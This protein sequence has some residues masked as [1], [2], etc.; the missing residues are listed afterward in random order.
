MIIHSIR[1][2]NVLKYTELTI[3]NLPLKGLIAITGPNE[4]GKSTIGETLCFALFGRT[5]SLDYED[6]KKVILWGKTHCSVEVE[7][8]TGDDQQFRLERFLDDSGNHSAH[9]SRVG[10][11]ED[12]E[13]LARGIEK[14]ADKL[15]E[16]IG[17][18]YDEFIESFY[19][20]QREITTPHPHSYA[21]KTM[22][23][24]TTL[25]YCQE[26]FKE[27]AQAAEQDKE[28]AQA[29]LESLNEQV[30]EVKLDAG[31]LAEL[32]KEQAKFNAQKEE[33]SSSISALDEA[34]IEYQEA[35]PK[36]SQA[37][38]SQGLAG[39]LRFV[40]LILALISGGS[41]ALLT[42]M[43]DHD[44]SLQIQQQ[45]Q[46]IPN[47]QDGMV[48]WL[49]YGAGAFAL[50][51]IAYWLRKSSLKRKH[52]QLGE[53]GQNLSSELDRLGSIEPVEEP[54]VTLLSEAGQGTE[55]PEEEELTIDV[56]E[57]NETEEKEQTVNHGA[58]EKLSRD[59]AGFKADISKVREGVAQELNQLHDYLD[60]IQTHLNQLDE[61][62]TE[63]RQKIAQVDGLN[64]LRDALISKREDRE[65]AIGDCQLAAELI[66]G[67][68]REIS[69][70]FNNK[71]RKLV[72][73]TL[74]KFTDG[75]YEHLQIADDL[76]V[77][78]F[79]SDKSDFMD[80]EEISSGTQRQ[81]MLAVRLAL[82]EELVG[83][84]VKSGQ[85]LFLDEP[86]AFFD[87]VRMRSSMRVLPE[88]S[89]QLNQ[90]WII[91]QE[92]PGDLSFDRHI[93]CE[94]ELLAINST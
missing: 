94:R 27:E 41:W 85:F 28:K 30:A 43:P 12:E 65:Q 75:R 53:T 22:A 33:I 24:L 87:Q 62:I 50:L 88:L 68:M 13:P 66:H 39:F 81:I 34:S 48:N 45:L 93:L 6:L 73:K 7:F 70:Q 78:A 5:F 67:S 14:V 83:R 69:Y 20:A 46:A 26:A 19:L 72:S 77:R 21:I 2:K 80:L 38:S 58:R 17:Y 15:F 44:L 61:A 10:P 91:G 57:I 25:E 55:E 3:E 42:Q 49:L 63:E 31:R 71:V 92:F 64:K 16:L 59:V 29:E 8:S 9:I 11:T 82:S 47:W 18:E 1:A 51:F 23:G 54:A 79:S 76:T 52:E 4:S 89:E 90:I 37:R 56:E 86:F 60:R 40:F 35:L 32:E 36:R 84:T 74:P